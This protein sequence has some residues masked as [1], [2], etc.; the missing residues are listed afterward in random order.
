M[1]APW[2][3]L[4]A[5]AAMAVQ[6]GA[7]DA[8]VGRVVGVDG[9]PSPGA[10]VL[11]VEEGRLLTLT[12]AQLD[13]EA[14]SSRTVADADGRFRLPK[15]GRRFALLAMDGRGVVFRTAEE[16]AG[17]FELS[18][19]PRGQISGTVRVGAS[20][21]R[22]SDGSVMRSSS[23]GRQSPGGEAASAKPVPPTAGDSFSTGC[24]ARPGHPGADRSVAWWGDVRPAAGSTSSPV[25]LRRGGHRRGVGTNRGGAAGLPR[26]APAPRSTG[27]RATLSR[28]QSPVPF[29]LEWAGWPAER[30]LAWRTAWDETP[31]GVAWMLG[32]NRHVALD[33]PRREFP[34]RGCAAWPLR[35]VCVP[36]ALL[37][38]S[39]ARVGA[40]GRGPGPPR[41]R[42]A[43]DRRGRRPRR[44]AHPARS[45]RG[46]G[47]AP[48]HPGGVGEPS[49]RLSP[50]RPSTASRCGCPTSAAAMSCSTSGRPGAV[51]AP[52]SCPTSGR[53]STRSAPAIVSP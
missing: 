37:S 5:L 7:D 18:L 8:L 28:K 2:G 25:R 46:H 26:R 19:R 50:S 9:R 32:Q 24:P 52:R 43:P 49:A 27:G 36:G 22:R 30:K 29:P 34:H 16:L 4:G 47:R 23:L 48:P 14:G 21:R 11:Q 39:P 51:R 53:R 6:V 15:P 40:A 33:A 17:S 10:S 41:A 45:D 42:T 1:R 31:E 38:R 3:V 44:R 12:G 35:P 13:P 20:T